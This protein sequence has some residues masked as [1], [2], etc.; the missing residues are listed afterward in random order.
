[1]NSL[2]TIHRARV[3]LIDVSVTGVEESHDRADDNND[4]GARHQALVLIASPYAP[5]PIYAVPASPFSA[6]GAP[7]IHPVPSPPASP[8]FYPIAPPTPVVPSPSGSSESAGYGPS[9]SRYASAYAGAGRVVR[10]QTK[11]QRRRIAGGIATLVLV[12]LAGLLPVYFLVIRKHRK[13]DSSSGTG[14]GTGVGGTGPMS[15]GDGSTVTTAQGDVI[16]KKQN[17]IKRKRQLYGSL[18]VYRRL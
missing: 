8:L 4:A 16:R 12:A 15:G 11:K 1:M 9:G 3:E 13:S 10:R 2:L 5:S 17:A 6:S 7:S 18:V 14:S